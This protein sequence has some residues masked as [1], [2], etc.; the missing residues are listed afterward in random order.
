MSAIIVGIIV[1]VTGVIVTI[2]MKPKND[3]KKTSTATGA[4]RDAYDSDREF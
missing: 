1:L 4:H 2:F 3:L